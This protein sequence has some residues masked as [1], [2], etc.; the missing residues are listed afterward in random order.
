VKVSVA[1][2]VG[3]VILAAAMIFFLVYVPSLAASFIKNSGVSVSGTLSSVL[4]GSLA[5]VLVYALAILVAGNMAIKEAPKVKGILKA[6]QGAVAGAFYYVILGGGTVT[7]SAAFSDFELDLTVTLL[8]TLAL[9]EISA[10]MRILQGVS[11][12][13]EGPKTKEIKP[14]VPPQT[15]TV[16]PPP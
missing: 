16:P 14:P 1:G 8:I 3:G 13:R 10:I 9:L 5:T 11:E 12:F 6:L 15:V 4:Q 7:M 2:T